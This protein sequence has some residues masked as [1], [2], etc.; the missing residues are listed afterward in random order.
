VRL[1]ARHLDEAADDA[2]A[3]LV[4]GMRLA[5]ED[6]LDLAIVEQRRQAFRIA[7]DQVA[8]LVRRRAPREAD[9][10]HVRRE[11]HAGAQC[12]LVEQLA[13]HHLMRRPE[14]VGRVDRVAD[15]HVLPR[16]CV[17]AVRDRN[18]LG[19]AVHVVPHRPRHL[20]VQLRHAVRAPRQP[21][22]RDRHVERVAADLQHLAVDEVARRAQAAE[23]AHR[24]HLVAGGDGRVCREDDLIADGLPRVGELLAAA[25]P[26]GDE[27]ESGEDRVAFVEVVRV[28]RDAELPE[29]AH[30]AD[31]EQD[32]LG[33]ARLRAGS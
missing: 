19:R 16:R 31:A 18:D 17:H 5:G 3:V 11:P 24:V 14:R 30:A 28:D 7:E 20:A 32:L 1:G 25:H 23:L 2:P 27:L 10:Q 22:A 15:A 6:E 4:V 33:D 9:R 12:D 13:L 8:P 26:F 21:E 29:R